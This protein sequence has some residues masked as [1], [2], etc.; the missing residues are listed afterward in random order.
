MNRIES[1]ISMHDAEHWTDD[2]GIHIL[3]HTR[4]P[5]TLDEPEEW[6]TWIHTVETIAAARYALGY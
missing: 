1:F 5:A 2:Q 6:L 3:E 4:K